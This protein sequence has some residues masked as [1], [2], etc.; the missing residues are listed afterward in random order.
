MFIVTIEAEEKLEESLQEQT[1]DSEVAMIVANPANPIELSLTLDKEKEGDQVVRSEGGRKILLVQS[2]LA[3][4]F[5]R[6]VFDHQETPQ[7]SYFTL[8][9]KV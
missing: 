3:T 5:E 8:S 2:N 4:E 9:A 7:C 1:A 6:M